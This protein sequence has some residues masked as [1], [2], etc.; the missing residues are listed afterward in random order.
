[1]DSFSLDFCVR[2]HHVYKAVW[3]T[4]VGETLLCQPEFGNVHDPYAVVIVTGDEMIVGHVPR[5]VSA[6]C[7]L[8]LRCCGHM[9]C[10]VTGHM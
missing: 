2:G 4:Q 3:T 6:I 7:D 1:M 8:F 10:Q 5:K 9:A